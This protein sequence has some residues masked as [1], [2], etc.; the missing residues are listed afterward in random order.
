MRG[1]LA[2]A[3][4]ALIPS[5]G[6]AATES[7]GADPR[8]NSY[9]QAGVMMGAAAPVAAP[10]LMAALEGGWR[11]G[12]GPTW[13]HAAATWGATGDDQGPG[14]NLQLRAGLER[15]SCWW[16]DVACGV[17]GLDAGYQKG[18]WSDRDDP[19]RNESSHG[20]VLIPRVGLDVG[21][22]HVRARAGLELDFG[23]ATIR[24]VNPA[25]DN[26]EIR[27]GVVGAEANL[28]VAYQW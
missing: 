14:G 10:N 4:L 3:G 9:L 28:G 12:A 11:W 18:H 20:P 2:A 5:M 27:T 1:V 13:L 17:G 24:E 8:P 26:K 23:L 6:F 15:R 21:G 19:T 16:R 22:R 25:T 7:P